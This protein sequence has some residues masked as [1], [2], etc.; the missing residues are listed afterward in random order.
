[1][2]SKGIEC[3]IGT[4]ACHAQSLYRERFGYRPGDLPNSYQAFHR[5]LA[6]PLHSRMSEHDVT[7]VV[8]AL[9]EALL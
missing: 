7:T 6:L 3:T 8:G 5:T 4:Y 9:K 1:M 2:R